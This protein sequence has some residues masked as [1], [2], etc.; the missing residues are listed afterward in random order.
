MRLLLS[1]FLVFTVLADFTSASSFEIADENVCE[2]LNCDDVD[3]NN[4]HNEDHDDG[5][6]Q[7]KCQCHMG[8]SHTAVVYRS[9]LLE[10]LNTKAA[11]K[12]PYFKQGKLQHYHSKII[13]PPIFS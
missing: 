7:H 12:Y 6:D 1:L 3:L 4:E 2:R 13:R 9:N 5:N 11:T 8:H 10:P